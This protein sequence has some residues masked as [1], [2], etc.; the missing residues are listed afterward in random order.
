MPGS[1]ALYRCAVLSTSS[2][3]IDSMAGRDSTIHILHLNISFNH[4]WHAD[5]SDVNNKEYCEWRVNHLDEPISTLPP[6]EDELSKTFNYLVE[7]GYH[8][9]IVT[10]LSHKLSDSADVIRKMAAQFPQLKIHV[11]DTGTCCMPEG[12]FAMEAERLLRAGLPPQ[13]VVAHLESLKPYCHIV[14]GLSSLKSLSLGGT[15]SRVGAS[16]GDWLGLRNVLH[17]SQDNLERLETVTDDVKMFDSIIANTVSLMNDKPKDQFILGGLYTG[18]EERYQLFAE[19]FFEKTGRRIGQG[20]PVSPVVA[21]HVGICGVGVGM[22]E[23]IA[24][25]A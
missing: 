1:Y 5:G 8:E 12:F 11:I 21:A 4:Q 13:T 7:Q 25:P 10:T 19:R 14:F 22:V 17:F 24:A 23:R 2:G 15:L 9:A 20:V 6:C 3:S 18:D 16:F